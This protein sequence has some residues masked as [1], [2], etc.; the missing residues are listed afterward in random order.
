VRRDRGSI[1]ISASLAAAPAPTSGAQIGRD[2]VRRPWALG[3]PLGVARPSRAIVEPSE[4][5][6]GS[7]RHRVKTNTICVVVALV[8]EKE[9]VVVT[10]WRMRR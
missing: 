8:S 6:N 2:H 10:T 7:W 3:T 1:R 5:E 4:F 9:A